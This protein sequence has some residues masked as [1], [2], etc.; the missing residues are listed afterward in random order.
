MHL[1][2]RNTRARRMLRFTHAL[3]GQNR[4]WAHRITK[5]ETELL[6]LTIFIARPLEA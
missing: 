2:N 5:R 6:L 3:T 1:N 4:S